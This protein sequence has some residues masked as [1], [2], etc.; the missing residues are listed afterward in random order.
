MCRLF[1]RR[2]RTATPH[3]GIGRVYRLNKCVP[4]GFYP[5]DA[6][7]M[8]QTVVSY[9]SP[10]HSTHIYSYIGRLNLR[11]TPLSIN[12]RC[13]LFPKRRRNSDTPSAIR[14]AECESVQRAHCTGYPACGL[15][16]QN[17]VF[18][19]KAKCYAVLRRMRPPRISAN[20]IAPMAHKTCNSCETQR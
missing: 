11:K 5:R 9:Y 12:T 1:I 10:I 18:D 15:S 7:C 13:F 4:I 8:S 6:G 16:Q 2:K 19:T 20:A 14:E 17:Y 3:Q